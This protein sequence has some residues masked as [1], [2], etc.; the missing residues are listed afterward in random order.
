MISPDLSVNVP[1]GGQ[2]PIIVRGR[3]VSTADARHVAITL[4]RTAYVKYQ[5]HASPRCQ[6]CTRHQGVNNNFDVS[7]S[8][9]STGAISTNSA[10]GV[11]LQRVYVLSTRVQCTSK[12]RIVNLTM[13]MR[14]LLAVAHLVLVHFSF[15]FRHSLGLINRMNPYV[16][17]D[18][19][20]NGQGHKRKRDKRR[21]NGNR[22]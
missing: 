7:P 3:E 15:F 9:R 19:Y 14:I 16:A 13:T 6:Q 17:A 21:V 5:M 1:H 12:I 4:L 8:R 10:V 2:W 22:Q 18:S 20:L 11:V